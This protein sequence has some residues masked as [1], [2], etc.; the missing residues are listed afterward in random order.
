[1]P[2]ILKRWTVGAALAAALGFIAPESAAA[3]QDGQLDAGTFEHSVRGSF[4]G[5]ETFAVRRRGEDVVAVGRVTRE[6]G[7]ETLRALEVGLRLD[8][9]GRP[10]RYELQTREG[11]GLHVVVNRTGSRL[12]VTTA[13]DEGERFTEFLADAR[14][15]LLEREIAHHYYDLARR[16]RESSDPRSLDL[17]VLVPSEGRT[18]SLRVRSRSRDT[19]TVEDARV[20]STR[21]EMSVGGEETLL[22]TA[23]EDG[24]I[25]RVAIPER[26]WQA[27]RVARR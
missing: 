22:W 27:T 16:I 5:T 6:G 12:R 14:L 18:V 3:Q 11:P 9:S 21:Y 2:R 26:G 10:M 20:S 15:V 8:R 1:M 13:A 25:M 17:E 24:R 23:T 7:P 4:A 19:V